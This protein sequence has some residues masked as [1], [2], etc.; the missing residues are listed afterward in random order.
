MKVQVQIDKKNI[1]VNF[2]L[3]K[4]EMFLKSRLRQSSFCNNEVVFHD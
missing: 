3:E 4:I 1:G 2:S